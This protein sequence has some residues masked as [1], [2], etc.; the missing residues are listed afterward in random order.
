KT[1][2]PKTLAPKTLAP[3]TL[4]PNALAVSVIDIP[5]PAPIASPDLPDLRVRSSE[6]VLLYSAV[7]PIEVPITPLVDRPVPRPGGGKL[8]KRVGNLIREITSDEDKPAME[9]V[10]FRVAFLRPANQTNQPISIS[11]VDQSGRLVA[12]QAVRNSIPPTSPEYRSALDGWWQV[13]VRAADRLNRSTDYPDHVQSYLVAMLSGRFGLPLPDSFLRVDP[14]SYTF[15]ESFGELLGLILGEKQ[16]L[17]GIFRRQASGIVESQPANMPL[18][19]P[20]AIIN[21]P[22]GG[23]ANGLGEV[24]VETLANYT[25]ADCFYLRY[26]SFNNYLWFRDLSDDFGGDLSTMIRLKGLENNSSAR[27]E[28][29]LN[30]ESNELSR[31]LGPTVIRDQAMIGYDLLLGDGPAVGVL[32]ESANAFLLRTSFNQARSARA[33]KENDV[34]LDTIEVAGLTVSRLMSADNRVRSFMTE[35]DGVFLITNSRTLVEAFALLG[36][37]GQALAQTP[38]FRLARASFSADDNHSLFAFISPGMVRRLVSPSSLIEMRRREEAKAQAEMTIL[39]RHAVAKERQNEELASLSIEQ[40]I[41]SGYL[42]NHLMSRPDSSGLLEVDRK[43][44]DSMR[45]SRGTYLPLADVKI[46]SV[47]VQESQWY[48]VI[49]GGLEAT[50]PTVDPIVLAIKRRESP[51]PPVIDGRESEVVAIEAMVAPWD[52]SKFGKYAKYLGPPTETAIRMAP[53]DIVSV[54]ASVDAQFLGPPTHLYAAI[55]DTTPPRPDDFD[56]IIKTFMALRSVPGYL[57]AWPSPG[58]LDRLPLGLGI[59]TPVGPGLNRLIGGLYRYTDGSYS[60][61]SFYPDIITNSLQHLEAIPTDSVAQLRARSGNLIGSQL[62]GYINQLLYERA[63]A[64]SIGGGKYLDSVA[65]QL[66]IDPQDA[67]EI[68]RRVLGEGVRDSL[69]GQYRLGSSGG[70]FEG[71]RWPGP[72]PSSV[73]PNGYIAPVLDWF[74]GGELLVTQGADRIGLRGEIAIEH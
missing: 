36:Q 9:S 64:A 19:A 44:I 11:L 8:L 35:R 12:T 72:L 27:I 37:G 16:W 30:L 41:Q 14:P 61:L 28:S 45:G 32:F 52:P 53:D 1:L 24:A 29:Q 54:Q 49:A 39:A 40:L 17:D 71:D 70:R 21:T 4:A 26:G 63:A 65:D 10:A 33:A 55:K 46:D 74:R 5:L 50:I 34:V 15:D 22:M 13:Y 69:G 18:P 73:P 51:I 68:A 47:T 62:E 57:G 38:E 60:I 25:P 23:L 7:A 31:L 20:A 6:G 48:Q 43:L 42:P 56:G 2:A 59:G 3:K 67:P 58:A 66:A